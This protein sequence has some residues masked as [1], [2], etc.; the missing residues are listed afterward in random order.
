MTAGEVASE[1]ARAPTREPGS[2]PAGDVALL[3]T[4][5]AATAADLDAL[6]PR[7]RAL[8]DHEGIAISDAT[9]AAALARL[10]AEPA[11]GNAWLIER[12]A[13][14]VGYAIVTFG[15]DLEFGGR[16][17]VLT[18]LWIDPEVRGGGAGAA[19]LE[20]L[21][22]VLRELGVGALHLQVR[23]ENPARHLYERTGFVASPRTVMTRK[24]T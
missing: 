11:L 20:A 5:R 12:G 14:T 22:P 10:L 17:A 7:T 23:P 8:N 3:T 19:A 21:V 16:D 13:A 18:E 1:A 6:L 15:Y 2:E 24:L 9:L 4:V